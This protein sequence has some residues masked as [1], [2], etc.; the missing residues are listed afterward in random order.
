MNRRAWITTALVGGLAVGAVALASKALARSRV[1]TP[2]YQLVASYPSFEHRR[3]APRLVA[4]VEVSGPSKQATNA[5]FRILADFIFGNNS[6]QTEVA[7]TAPVDRTA[8][9]TIEMT[10]P[11]DRTPAEP[12]A[13]QGEDGEDQ[14]VI[15]FTMPSKYTRETLPQ[16]NDARVKIREI[17]PRDYAVM[18]FSGAPAEAKVEAKIAAFIAEVEDAGLE[19]SGAPPTYAR[20]DPPWTPG[21][22]RRNEIFIELAL[23]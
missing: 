14:W 13:G 4:E 22:L 18:R 23:E 11:V 16:P 17:P 9:E 8:S 2:D 12:D 6:K 7:M 1:E 19:R 10:A 20:Y 5:G 15:A 21:F 3:Y